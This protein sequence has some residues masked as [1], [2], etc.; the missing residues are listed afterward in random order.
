MMKRL[1][2]LLAFIH[3]FFINGQCDLAITDVNLNTYEVTVEVFNGEGCGATGYNGSNDHINMVMIGFHVP[4]LNEAVD[5]DGPDAPCFMSETSN[6][7]G[8]WFGTSASDFPGNFA[9]DAFPLQTGDVFT[10]P[11]DNPEEVNCEDS[12][13][14][15]C[16]AVDVIDYWLD[17]GECLEFVIWQINYS[18]SWY[19]FDGPNAP[20]GGWA[21]VGPLD[22]GQQ[23]ISNVQIYPDMDC[24]NSWSVCRDENPG[25]PMIQGPNV[26]CD[27]AVVVVPGCTDPDALNYEPNA[28]IDD[29]SCVYPP[30]GSTDAIVTNINFNTGCDDNNEPW[31]SVQFTITNMGDIDINTYCVDLWVPDSQFCY[32][33]AV[34]G[35]YQIPPG[36]GQTFSTGQYFGEWNA[37]SLFTINVNTVNDEIITGNN[38]TT[39]FM[40]ELPICEP[41]EGCTDICA[42][43]YDPSAD[44]DDGSCEY[45]IQ[46][47]TVYVDVPVYITDTVYVTEYDTVEI[48]IEVPVYITDT[49]YI[50]EYDTVEI[51]IEVPVYITDTVEIEVVEYVYLTDTITEYI[52]VDCETGEPCIDDP[53]MQECWPWTV[54]IPNTFTPNNDGFNDVWQMIYDLNCWVDVEFRIFNRWGSEI[55]HGYGDDYDSYPY[56]NGS[57]NNGSTYVS[58]GVYTYTFYAKHWDSPEVYYRTGHITVFR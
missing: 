12:P 14:I 18:N 11:L 40:P 51:E 3:S 19:Q 43:N 58:D 32:D 26:D 31:Y 34:N 39:V 55:Y 24:D 48:E 17:Q 1:I 36:E 6:H 49:L 27:G 5:V 9:S 22:N 16:C 50:T 21:E 4:G 53:G 46:I 10:I 2:F 42:L 28:T 41:N 13:S 54:Y 57:V 38:N 25:P 37:G 35:L 20:G 56:W 23:P 29:G 45:E 52:P 47:D 44:L 33:E 15:G 30:E 8:W 7:P